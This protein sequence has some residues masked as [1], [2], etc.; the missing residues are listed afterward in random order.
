MKKAKR[1]EQESGERLAEPK[2][3][4]VEAR[5]VESVGIAGAE[6]GKQNDEAMERG[7]SVSMEG[8]S[9]HGE[10]QDWR[11]I[12]DTIGGYKVAEDVE[13]EIEKE[14]TFFRVRIERHAFDAKAGPGAGKNNYV[15][16]Y[17]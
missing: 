5:R 17:R 6:C 15:S 16:Q 2:V 7:E 4:S 14:D 1:R 12:L 13:K 11:D 3:E 8:S 10:D 9:E